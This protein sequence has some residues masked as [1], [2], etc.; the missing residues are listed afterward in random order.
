MEE[1]NLFDLEEVDTVCNE[2]SCAICYEPIFEK[3]IYMLST[4]L[5]VIKT[6]YT[7]NLNNTVLDGEFIYISKEKKYLYMI[8]DCLFYK[9]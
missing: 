1:I 5:N 9:G 8:F 3:N 2:N 6:D 4:N 7:S